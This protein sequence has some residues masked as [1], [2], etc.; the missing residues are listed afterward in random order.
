MR[1]SW[2]VALFPGL[3]FVLPGLCLALP[4]LRRQD[5]F[6]RG[7]VLA[8]WS[9]VDM[10][11]GGLADASVTVAGG[12]AERL[13]AAQYVELLFPGDTV[14]AS[15]LFLKGGAAAIVAVLLILFGVLTILLPRQRFVLGAV[16][17]LGGALA[18]GLAAW[19]ALGGLSFPGFVRWWRASRCRSWASPTRWRRSAWTGAASTW[20]L[21]ARPICS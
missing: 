21:A 17:G 14:A 5:R 2:G 7:E 1:R 20:W 10:T 4:F 8:G 13:T 9:G 18:L 15:A 16:A 12:E 3:L 6:A 11:I 19:L